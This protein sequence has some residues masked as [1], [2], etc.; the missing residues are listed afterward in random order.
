MEGL[1]VIAPIVVPLN[2]PCQMLE[3]I[4]I[5]IYHWDANE[6]KSNCFDYCQLY[7]TFQ[8]KGNLSVNV[9]IIPLFHDKN[10]MRN[11][12]DENGL[13]AVIITTRIMLSYKQTIQI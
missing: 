11:L 8:I 4:L 9:I 1:G 5:S 12:N 2:V 7:T 6:I 10:A 13:L 3:D